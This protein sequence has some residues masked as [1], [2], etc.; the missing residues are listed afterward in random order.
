[1]KLRE[2]KTE[3]SGTFLIISYLTQGNYIYEKQ[4][5]RLHLTSN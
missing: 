2:T 4:H 5:T 3:N 1:M